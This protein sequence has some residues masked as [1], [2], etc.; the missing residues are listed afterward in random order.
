M[1]PQAKSHPSAATAE[2][3]SKGDTAASSSAQAFP[4]TKVISDTC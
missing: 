4:S 1:P 3:Q 2:A